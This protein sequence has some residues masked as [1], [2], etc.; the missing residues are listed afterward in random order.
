MAVLFCNSF[1]KICLNWV[2]FL[3]WGIALCTPFF[4]WS[5]A[6]ADGLHDLDQYIQNVQH[7]SARFTQTVSSPNTS[8]RMKKS[9]GTFY[10]VRPL[11]FR[12]DYEK[13]FIQHTVADGKKLW[14]YDQ[15]LNQVIQRDQKKALASTPAALLATA[16][17]I[18]DLM[19][20]FKL[21]N[22]PVKDSLN[23]VKATP[24]RSDSQIQNIL[25]G[26]DNGHLKRLIILDGLSQQSS[27]EF[28]T[29]EQTRPD[30]KKFQFSPPQNAT[31]LPDQ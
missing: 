15:S 26:F 12:F 5:P 29:F 18:S 4:M 10:F 14:I 1:R 8:K 28:D 23:W 7:G 17:N 6:H 25:M 9:S 31:I 27:I 13:P 16:K 19:V 11:H 20:H 22:E 3:K 2:M 21:E 30:V 24:V